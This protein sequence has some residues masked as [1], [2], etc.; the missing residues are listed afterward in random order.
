MPVF[1][2]K[3]WNGQ[4]AILDE[5]ESRH[6]VR[7]LR[8][9]KD[10]PVDMVDGAGNLYRG[11]IDAADPQKTRVRILETIREHLARRYQL[12]IA[13]A[14]TKSMDRFEWFLEKSTEIGIDE[15]T[16]VLCERSERNRIRQD[17]SERILQA[18]MKQTGRAYLT[19]LNSMVPLRELLEQAEADFKYIAHCGTSAEDLPERPIK[20]N[21]SW[22]VLIGPEGDFTHEE[23]KMTIERNYLEINLGEAVYRTETAGIIACQLIM[24]LAIGT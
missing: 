20:A 8:L 6:L 14:P 23:L 19:K 4:D 21:S 13:I 11:V 5:E 3:N 16:P 15:I 9:K 10:D 7:V 2:V 1:F 17:R 12:H 18:A 24:F 22:L